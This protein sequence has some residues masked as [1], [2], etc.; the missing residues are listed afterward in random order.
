MHDLVI[1]GALLVDGSGAEPQK[2]DVTVSSGRIAAIEAPG[3]KLAARETVDADGLALMPGI[4]DNHTHYDA[5]VTWD[6]WCSPSPQLGVTTAVIGNCGFTIA[7]CR[8][9]DRDRIMR[10]LTQVEGMSLEV[11]RAGIDWQFESVP[12]YLALIERRGTVPNV[13]AFVGHSSLR[14]FV[15]GDD[16]SRRPATPA[17]IAR[18]RSLLAEGLRA[19]AIGF[20][21]STSPAHNGEAGVPM[22]SRL[23][24]DGELRELVASLSNAPGS[25]FML[26]KGGHTR[27]DFLEDLAAQSGGPVI[28]AALLHNSTNPGAVFAD[29]DAIEAARGRGRRMVGAVSACPLTN[30]FTLHSPYPVEGLQ[31]W[32]PLLP[33]K[34]AAFVRALKSP[35]RRNAI[36]AELAQPAVFRLFNGEW[37]KVQVVE[38]QRA[39]HRHFEHRSIAELA[40]EAGVDPLDFMLD[41]A[42][43][44]GLDTVFSAVLLNSD[45]EAVARLLRHPASLVSLSDAGA[46]LTF[47]N[48]AGFG[49]HLLGHWVRE[50]GVLSLAEAVRKLTA[51]P[52]AVFGLVDR[53]M[54]RPGAWAD[55]MLFDPS[56][57]ARGG[58]TRVNDL[59]AG[60]ARLI[61]PPVGLHG[62]WVNGQRVID[63]NGQPVSMPSKDRWPGQLLR[64]R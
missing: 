55:L 20:A 13:A 22:P 3:T 59:P 53:G 44:E 42:I 57:V 32:Q 7:P 52:A 30:D 49:L 16:A 54:I 29:L 11:L 17:E 50:R 24:D 6:P 12:D 38:T 4:I 37:D 41:L 61:T 27:I 34:G 51:E 35:E 46:H 8:P 48:D 56:T 47:F 43:A 28:V 60:G 45:E 21:T 36:R 23:A 1:R 25:V 33:L 9:G 31:S 64:S 10:N 58:K 14:T 18:M 26:T 15:M 5:Q 39:S 40:G 2:A 63:R 19:G 62:V